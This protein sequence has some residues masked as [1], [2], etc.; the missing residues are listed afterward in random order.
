MPDPT[1]DTQLFQ[2]NTL[3]TTQPRK[4]HPCG[5][6]A[7]RHALDRPVRPSWATALSSASSIRGF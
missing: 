7:L 1:N 3:H 2:V 4:H 5:I 6:I